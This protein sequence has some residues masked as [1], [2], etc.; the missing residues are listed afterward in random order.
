LFKVQIC[1]C[2]FSKKNK[3]QKA[4][5]GRIM[6]QGQQR[7]KVSKTPSQQKVLDVVVYVYNPGTREAQVGWSWSEGS[8]Q[9]KQTLSEK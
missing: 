9:Q 5:I 6:V 4:E 3:H 8:P 7:Q 1:F 2:F